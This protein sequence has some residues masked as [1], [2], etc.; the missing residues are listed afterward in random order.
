MRLSTLHHGAYFLLLLEYWSNGPLPDDAV[1][2][3]AIARMSPAGWRRVGP[4]ILPFFR[5]ENGRLYQ[6]R[7]DFERQR[8]ET[9]RLKRTESANARWAEHNAAKER[10]N[11]SARTPDTNALRT[12]AGLTRDRE[13]EPEP[14]LER[15][16][17]KP[18]SPFPQH[19]VAPLALPDWMPIE[20]W[21]AFIEMRKS[22]K[23]P[24][25]LKAIGLL[26]RQL[27]GFH[28]QG[29]DVAEA[30][31]ASTRAGWRG[32]FPPRGGGGGPA[33]SNRAQRLT[34]RLNG[35]HRKDL[36]DER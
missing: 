31:N 12:E 19:K 17:E 7:S 34:N 11:A 20:P 23:H 33:R 30:L 4:A 32:V 1:T 22:S 25:T 3:A 8:V 24:V 16:E 18:P 13:S 29:M 6:K 10:A 2:L 15:K 14:E 35:M 28:D 36:D 5:R 27:Q 26:I 9:R 21:N